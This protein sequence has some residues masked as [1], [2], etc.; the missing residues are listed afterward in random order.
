M[1]GRYKRVENRKYNQ[2]E[3]NYVISRVQA[4][5]DADTIAKAFKQDHGQYWGEREFTK[6]QVNYI[7]T[8]YKLPWG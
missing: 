5:W 4:N 6:K 7:R 3:I 8:T 1:T 2:D